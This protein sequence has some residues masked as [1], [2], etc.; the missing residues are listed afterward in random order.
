[1]PN[2]QYVWNLSQMMW[3]SSRLVVTCFIQ[4]V[5]RVGSIRA[6]RV[7]VISEVLARTVDTNCMVSMP[8]R[9]AWET[10]ADFVHLHSEPD[11]R[12]GRTAPPQNVE[13]PVIGRGQLHPIS[14]PNRE[15][16]G[17][18]EEAAAIIRPSNSDR[19]R[20]AND[21]I[22]RRLV[23]VEQQER[24]EQALAVTPQQYI[25][26]RRTLQGEPIR[27]DRRPRAVA[28]EHVRNDPP[29]QE[30]ADS[31]PQRTSSL[32]HGGAIRRQQA[33]EIMTDA[34][35]INESPRNSQLDNGRTNSDTSDH[36]SNVGGPSGT[37]STP[38][39]ASGTP[40]P[41][42]NTQSVQPRESRATLATRAIAQRRSLLL[43]PDLNNRDADPPQTVRRSASSSQHTTAN[44][45]RDPIWLPDFHG[46]PRVINPQPELTPTERA[47]R[48][49]Q[50]EQSLLLDR[51]REVQDQL[52]RHLQAAD[53]SRERT[54]VVRR[55][56]PNHFPREAQDD[57]ST[58]RPPPIAIP[59]LADPAFPDLRSAREFPDRRA[60]GSG[61]S[62][63]SADYV[64][65]RERNNETQAPGRLLPS[66]S[67]HSGNRPTA[68]PPARISSSNEEISSSLV[69]TYPA[70]SSDQ[71][72]ASADNLGSRSRF[73]Q[74][75]EE[76]L[77]RISREQADMERLISNSMS[78][79]QSLVPALT[80]DDTP[81]AP[82]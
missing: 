32:P 31:L 38:L 28:L 26:N 77:E 78:L 74:R 55:P 6:R 10:Y 15:P 22:Q 24:A 44:G 25:T 73:R 66:L 2:V 60:I 79:D 65:T 75:A 3:S 69:S 61:I 4:S 20:Q 52:G 35:R 18:R 43:E 53:A 29:A 19:R 47:I 80:D 45:N 16:F 12:F 71:Q 70:T 17:H 11:P 5:Y 62:I 57:L 42:V 48:D 56:A 14:S 46:H 40:T 50:Q 49:L 34:L 8:V 9:T 1:M 21:G 23:G 76:V 63:W 64:S 39:G 58:G 27:I 72:P 30:D 54:T 82:Q 68:E 59:H 41:T 51:L 37:P 7:R 67:N 33:S 81:E 13:L 36:V